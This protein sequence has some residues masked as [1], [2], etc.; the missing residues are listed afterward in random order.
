MP[1]GATA[2]QALNLSVEPGPVVL[3][4]DDFSDGT[5]APWQQL[6]A[7]SVALE[8]EG[9]GYVLRKSG[10]GDPNGGWAPLAAPVGDFELV[11][12]TRKA[13]LDPTWAWLRYSLTTVRWRRLRH[14]ARPGQG[15]PAP[16]AA[17]RLVA[18]RS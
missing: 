1:T 13:T 6:L 7:G 9:S 4:E 10:N 11:V 8:P 16:G 2:D 15:N 12:Q 17:H 5:L 14:R 3:L 18:Q